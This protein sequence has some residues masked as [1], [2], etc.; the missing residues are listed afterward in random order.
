MDKGKDRFNQNLLADEAIIELYWNRNERAIM[1]TDRKYKGYLYTIAHNIL[2]DSMD[3]EECLNDT[4]LG[5][6][7]AIPPERPSIFQAFLSKIMRNTAVV[8]YKKNTASKRVPS[9]M[10]VSLAELG[11]SMPYSPSAED[12]YLVSQVS[13][14]VSNFLRSLP[15][16]NAFIFI[17]RYYCSDRIADIASMLHISER[18]VYRELTT[19][20]EELKDILTKEGYYHA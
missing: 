6:W 8:R 1:E 12:E 5:T 3:C 7:N 15:E 14:I 4:Y 13:R 16:R 11:D 9:E 19:M 2:H 20:R 10:S 17:C 18:S